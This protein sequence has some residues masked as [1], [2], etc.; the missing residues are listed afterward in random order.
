[1]AS[2]HELAKMLIQSA[3]GVQASDPF[4][5][6]A[7][8]ITTGLGYRYAMDAAD[9]EKASR[10]KLAELLATGD[11]KAALAFAGQSDDPALQ[12]LFFESSLKGADNTIT[13]DAWG[14]PIMVDKTTGATKPLQGIQTYGQPSPQPTPQ[15]PP[16][17]IEQRDLPP[18]QEPVMP[19][20][21]APPSSPKDELAQALAR[22]ENLLSEMGTVPPKFQSTYAPKIA[23]ANEDIRALREAAKPKELPVGALKLQDEALDAYNAAGA[24][25]GKTTEL[26]NKLDTGELDVGL[27]RNAESV[28]RNWL[29]SPDTVSINYD[30]LDRA[31]EKM[32]N[33]TLLLN[34][35]VQ[36][37]GDAQ[38]AMNA[39]VKN[40]RDP[41]LLK[42]AL[43]DLK[44]VNDR[45]ETLQS[46]RVNTI[47]Q[48][49]G[50]GEYQMP[51][52]AQ[53]THSYEE[54]FR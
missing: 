33:D 3:G 15:Q 20:P 45:A 19:L 5:G 44:D 40:R 30:Q 41:V 28:V 36:T 51:G 34:K 8:G 9:E 21:K 17:G 24:V 42:Q 2:K 16:Q 37:E 29:G 43:Q 54:Y 52:A 10:K 22:R 39:V 12:N 23:A 13:Q 14:N 1:M 6:L 4:T 32:R 25:K 31:L 46:N 35:G 7:K 48:N 11:K 50:L 53:P 26:M 27:L 18:I 47:R 49:F 38:R